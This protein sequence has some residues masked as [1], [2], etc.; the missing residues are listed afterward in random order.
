MNIGEKIRVLR[1]E[2]KMTLRRLSEKSGVALATLSRIETDKMV[3]TIES[4]QSIASALNISLSELY[5][6]MDN[7]SNPIEYQPLK[8]RTD[9]FKH[10]ENASYQMLTSK[11]LSKKMMPVM[12]KI[13]PEAKSSIEKLPKNTERFIYILKGKCE[14][15][16]ESDKHLLLKGETLYF[17]A[18]MRHNFKNTG[19]DTLEAI[20]IIT[21]PAL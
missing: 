8:N 3:G 10:N 21:P 13:D 16:I 12:L 18:S 20:S 9:I 2:K 6:D 11:V 17:D 19:S 5:A 1:K 14:V 4:H 15:T 7:R